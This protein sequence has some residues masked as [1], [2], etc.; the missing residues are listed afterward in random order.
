MDTNYRCKKYMVKKFSEWKKR[1]KN[2]LPSVV[3]NFYS[4]ERHID[5]DIHRT[6]GRV[7]MNINDSYYPYNPTSTDNTAEDLLAREILLEIDVNAI[8]SFVSTHH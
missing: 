7:I 3:T 8:F 1:V 6:L 2:R 4:I 5:Y